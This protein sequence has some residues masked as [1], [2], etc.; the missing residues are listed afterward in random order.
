MSF[1]VAIC[2]GLLVK[3]SP[4]LATFMFKYLKTV[5][6]FGAS[7]L[8]HTKGITLPSPIQFSM[9]PSYVGNTHRVLAEP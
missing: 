3:N 7:L 1:E 2:F 6:A 9:V 5:G 8:D 4:Q